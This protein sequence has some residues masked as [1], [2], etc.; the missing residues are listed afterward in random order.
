[1]SRL[2]PVY[3]YPARRILFTI[4]IIASESFVIGML[5]H[6]ICV[7]GKSQTESIIKQNELNSM[8]CE[9]LKYFP[10]PAE[11][12][13]EVS[14]EDS[15][16]AYRNN[17]GH[18]GC[19]IMDNENERGRIPVISGTDGIITNIGWLYLGGYRIGIT[20]DNG[21]YYYYAHLDSYALGLQAGD[22]VIAGQLLGFMGD[23]GEGE[24]GTR[25]MFPVHLH[26]GIYT[27]MSEGNEQ[28]VDSY[29]FLLNVISESR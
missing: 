27:G 6:Y 21:V 13:S 28:A 1:M 11:Y 29:P 26:F 22:K 15:F 25:G 5:S 2:F 9:D 18:E 14:F 4:V 17:G 10:I 24:E 8:I 12:I 16:G 20:S 3:I 23:S 7:L 19:D